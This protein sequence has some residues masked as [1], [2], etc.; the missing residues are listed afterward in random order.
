LEKDFFAQ[1][2]DF[3]PVS[4]VNYNISGNTVVQSCNNLTNSPLLFPTQCTAPLE[5]DPHMGGCAFTCPLPALTSGQ[6]YDAKVMQGVIGWFSWVGT[7][8]L[9]INFLAI[10]SL[11]S[12]PKNMILM[13]GIAANIAAGAIIL[14][15]YAGY[16]NI[17]CGGEVRYFHPDFYIPPPPPNSTETRN[18]I[19]S[20]QYNDLLTPSS[21]CTF[22]GA[23]LQFGYLAATFWWGLI[24]FNIF[25][26]VY[27]TILLKLDTRWG[28]WI[29]IACYHVVGWGVPF[30]FMVI[31]AAADRIKFA[32]GGTYCFVTPEDNQA[33]QLVFW[34]LP[35]G[36]TL[37]LGFTFFVL[38]IV[39]IVVVMIMLRK[40]AQMW[41]YIRLLIFIF[42]YLFLFCF[43]FSY[44]IQLEVDNQNITDGYSDYFKCLSDSS[45]GC[46]LSSDV[47][48][49]SLIMLNGFAISVLGFLL[50]LLFIS[51]EILKFWYL[52]GKALVLLAMHR[53]YLQAMAMWH[54]F[55][56][57]GATS[58][59][60]TSDQDLSVAAGDTATGKKS[61]SGVS[62]E[63]EE[64]NSAKESSSSS[65]DSDWEMD[66]VKGR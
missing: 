6:Y 44:H 11:R 16:D 57:D 53:N 42:L 22:Q 7:A 40:L 39:R 43:I 61:A 23:M 12:F 15:T 31:P 33:Y 59:L 3:W 38:A 35:V 17:W 47:S 2:Q 24:A 48:N 54:L 41:R 30:L 18:Y 20:F 25:M 36:I 56:K 5:Y 63:E 37:L 51:W 50:F 46:E 21:A 26:E 10:P 32:P 64:G 14:P 60:S 66:K 4:T 28:K 62:G 34:F 8:F 52:V 9:F 45:L 55:S 19:L 65:D 13:T 27:F 58:S 1:G 49:Y 29:R